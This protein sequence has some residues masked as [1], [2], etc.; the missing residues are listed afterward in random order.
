MVSKMIQCLLILF[1]FRINQI[2]TI[3]NY[4]ICNIALL[5]T[6]KQGVEVDYCRKCRCDLTDRGEHGKIVE[7]SYRSTIYSD[8]AERQKDQRTGCIHDNHYKY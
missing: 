7:Q 1:V 8:G 6:D 4:P 2:K 5:T 3:K